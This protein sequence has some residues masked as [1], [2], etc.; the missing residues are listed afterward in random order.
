MDADLRT[1]AAARIMREFASNTGL[2]GSAKARRYLWTD[3]FAVCNFL[4]LCRRTGD[5]SFQELAVRLADQVHWILGRHR[6]DDVRTGWLGG[7][8]EEEGREHP[9]G[10]GL[11]IGKSLPERSIAEDFDQRLE[12][13]RD[14]QYFHYLTKWMTALHRLA[15]HTGNTDYAR[16]GVELARAAHKGFT[17]RTEG[18]AGLGMFWK[19]SIDLSRPLIPSMGHHDP[20]D[21]YLT[22]IELQES[23]APGVLQGEIEDM[24]MMCRGRDWTTDDPLGLGGILC[25][26]LRAA[27]L[28]QNQGELG[29]LLQHLLEAAV[30]GLGHYARQEPFRESPEYRLAFRE[31]GLSI[32]LQGIV[33]IPDY[34]NGW[35]AGEPSLGEMYRLVEVLKRFTDMGSDIESQW[36]L[37]ENQRLSSWTEHRDI[38]QVMLATSLIPR[39]FLGG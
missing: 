3:A 24:K 8:S 7:Q 16:Y 28:G 19:M 13:E 5:T 32:G 22:Y 34:L 25:D 21:G 4:E 31:L 29:F 20:L 39:T 1:A 35:K 38:N 2:T 26:C 10:G 6:D 23:C 12:W 14:G 27:R 9:T 30:S 17:Y 18:A 11:R 37:P 33:S 36:L 15:Q